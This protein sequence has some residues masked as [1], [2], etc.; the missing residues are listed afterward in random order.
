MKIVYSVLLNGEEVCRLPDKPDVEKE[1]VGLAQD[2]QKYWD[3]YTGMGKLFWSRSYFVTVFKCE[4]DH[5][6]CLH[7]LQ[8]LAIE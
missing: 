5:R 1:V 8:E 4:L 2:Y 7:F 3:E 6:N